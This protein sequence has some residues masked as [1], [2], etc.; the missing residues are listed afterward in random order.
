MRRDGHL[1]PVSWNDAL[2][3]VAARIRESKNGSEQFVG[4]G[5]PRLT[6][7]DAY[8]MQRFVR[9]VAGSPHISSGPVGGVGALVEGMGPV[10]G[11]PRS[12]ATLEELADAD[13]VVVLRGDP[14]RTHPL[15][16]TELVQGVRQRGQ[17][18]ILAHALSGGLERHAA[19]YLP[20]E[21]GTEDVLVHGVA[22]ELLSRN[23]A[24]ADPLRELP[25]FSEWSSSTADYTPDLVASHT[26]IPA[27]QCVEMASMFAEARK[28]V[29]VVVTGL[30]IPGDEGSVTRATA[31]LMS[32][33]GGEEASP[34]VL[35]LGEKANVQGVIDV[36]LHPGLLP[37]HRGAG[38]ERARQE[39]EG[40]WG[41]RVPP[42]PGWSTH[43]SF[44]HAARGEVGR[45]ARVHGVLS[46]RFPRAPSVLRGAGGFA[47]RGGLRRVLV[48]VDPFHDPSSPHPDQMFPPIV[49]S[50]EDLNPPALQRRFVMTLNS[51]GSTG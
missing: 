20:L 40:L 35:V 22:A 8:L 34:A 25:G 12:N 4:L 46:P 10:T 45:E 39:L 3:T 1:V 5:S 27:A 49:R 38:D 2:D 33:L 48:A 24:A 11:S 7:E 14:A 23:P 18:L 51:R 15:I 9:S 44:S 6:T 31:W 29:A 28:V 16:K 42:G 36:G 19:M 21:P 32:L 37:G 17:K 43:E 41:A 50:N 13:L 47:L 30:G 26:G